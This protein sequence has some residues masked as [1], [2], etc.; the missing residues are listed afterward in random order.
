[1]NI[2]FNPA[3]RQEFSEVARWYADEA[4]QPRAMDFRNEVHRSLK[5]LGE[6]PS[7]GSPSTSNTRSLVV[8]RYPYSVVYRVEESNLRVLAVASHSRRP[9][10]WAG[11]R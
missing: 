8:H 10:Y 5:L 7:L 3:A 9:G 6:H 4:G 2:S 1:M 11:R